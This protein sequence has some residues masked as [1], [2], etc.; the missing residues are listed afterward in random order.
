MTV[1]GFQSVLSRQ[2]SQPGI[3]HSKSSAAARAEIILLSVTGGA[4]RA[5]MAAMV[6]AR[7]RVLATILLVRCISWLGEFRLIVW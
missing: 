6:K 1:P 3:Q 5:P 4:A 7:G 2:E